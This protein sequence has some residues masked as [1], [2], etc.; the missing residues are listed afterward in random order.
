MGQ[1]DLWEFL[2]CKKF[3]F[4]LCVFEIFGRFKVIKITKVTPNP[5]LK[6]AFLKE[7]TLPPEKLSATVETRSGAPKQFK[8]LLRVELI[9]LAMFLL[10][11]P[12]LLC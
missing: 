9:W 8:F 5:T 6:G 1:G 10:G 7:L 4:R 2:F 3:P 12:L 11:K